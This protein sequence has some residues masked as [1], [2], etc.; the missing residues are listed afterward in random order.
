[1]HLAAPREHQ[2]KTGF[3]SE[4]QAKLF[5]KTLRKRKGIALDAFPCRELLSALL[6]KRQVFV[7]LHQT[8]RRRRRGAE[9]N[10]EAILRA[11]MLATG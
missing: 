2:L 3:R 9:A 7:E 10:K 6:E 1:M 11:S 8:R 5:A 4:R